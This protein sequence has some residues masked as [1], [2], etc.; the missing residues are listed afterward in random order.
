[1]LIVYPAVGAV[2]VKAIDAVAAPVAGV[3]EALLQLQ[4]LV[5]LRLLTALLHH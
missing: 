3:R 4:L 1:M 2:I 5:S